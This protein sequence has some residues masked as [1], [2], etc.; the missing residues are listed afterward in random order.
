[1]FKEKPIPPFDI[2]REYNY[3]FQHYVDL[4]SNI[5]ELINQAATENLDI[6]AN[7]DNPEAGF[8]ALIQV[9]INSSFYEIKQ[10]FIC[11]IIV[12]VLE[13]ICPAPQK[14]KF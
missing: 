11:N 3:S 9:F 7:Y 1:M 8:D 10:D 14:G 6:T 13:A 12:N 5:Q 4:T 2:K